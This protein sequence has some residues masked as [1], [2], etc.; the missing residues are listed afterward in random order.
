MGSK[1]VW[2]CSLKYNAFWERVAVAT[3]RSGANL[4]DTLENDGSEK[5]ERNM[6]KEMNLHQYYKFGLSLLQWMLIV[7]T[8][9]L[10]IVGIHEYLN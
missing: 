1:I 8:T 6:T 7:G 10:L 9:G 3:R 5:R 4:L 2:T